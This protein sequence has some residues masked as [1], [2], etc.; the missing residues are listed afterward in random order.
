MATPTGTFTTLPGSPESTIR[1]TNGSDVLAKLNITE[2][3]RIESLGGIDELHLKGNDNTTTFDSLNVYSGDAA[4]SI[5][6]HNTVTNSLL[7]GGRGGDT[8]LIGGG[9]TSTTVRGG[10]ANDSL[11]SHLGSTSSMINGNKDIDK[12][13][14]G[15]THNS[16]S[17]HGGD[18]NDTF[19]IVSG[20]LNNTSVNGDKGDDI[21]TDQ[22]QTEI[23][24]AMN[25]KSGLYGN[26]GNDSITVTSLITKAIAQGGAGNDTIKGGT[27]G[28]ALTG[29]AGEDVL[30]GNDG[31]DT[32]AGSDG[33]DTITGGAGI[34]SIT[35]GDG[36]DV[37][38]YATLAA[39]VTGNAVVDTV[40]GGDATDSIEVAAALNIAAADVLTRT[41][42]VEQLI[43]TA[44][45]AASTVV[46]TTDLRLADIRTFD[47]SANGAT[48]SF[49]FTGVTNAIELTVKTGAGAD[50]VLGGAGKDSIEGGDGADTLKGGLGNDTIKGGLGADTITGGAGADQLTGDALSA[51]DFVYVVADV[52]DT[53]T[54]FTVGVDD[55]DWN[56]TLKAVNGDATVVSQHAAKGTTL[57]VDTTVFELEGQLT[58]GTEADLITD[59]GATL[60]NAAVTTGDNILIA[61]YLTAGG[62]QIWN[63]IAGQDGSFA[64]ADLTL[65]ATLTG[66][67][68]DS[69]LTGNFI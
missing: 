41:D 40:D 48:D 59:A 44:T 53:I 30:E 47:Y 43:Q 29:G 63:A 2:K 49:N 65:V 8:I 60:I 57:G 14:I 16:S 35:G 7:Q 50:S 64:A 26:D 37:I 11:T 23:S 22:G 42:N 19:T 17:I 31:A 12:L 58:D 34:D 9:L 69:L 1:G 62:A 33:A 54:N 61:S 46:V 66:V 15:N 27:I 5:T 38:K 52:G 13:F 39:F 28:D 21:F 10:S 32:L 56:T 45:N 51:N 18:G 24:F 3:L 55:I 20:I 36:I 25:G 4:D 68:A 6:T 67:D